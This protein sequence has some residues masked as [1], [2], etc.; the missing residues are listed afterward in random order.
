MKIVELK[1]YLAIPWLVLAPYP[2]TRP[3]LLLENLAGWKS[4]MSE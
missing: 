3:F 4:D 2:A 1:A